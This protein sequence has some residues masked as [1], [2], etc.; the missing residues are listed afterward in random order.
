M[1]HHFM[2]DVKDVRVKQP[3]LFIEGIKCAFCLM[4]IMVV[5]FCLCFSGEI[6][7]LFG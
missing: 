5:V 1:Q 4:G 2:Q 3:N 7:K 6:V